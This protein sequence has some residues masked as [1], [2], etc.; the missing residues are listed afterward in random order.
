MWADVVAGQVR[1]KLTDYVGWVGMARLTALKI[2]GLV[3]PGRYGDGDGLWLQVRDAE[4]RSWLFRFTMDGR[5]R[6]MGL[7]PFPDVSLADAREAARK[8]RGMVREGLDPIANRRQQRAE[9]LAA[10]QAQTFA[11]V[12]ERYLGAHEAV[13]RNDKHRYQ[14]RQT[15]SVAS[16]AFG[17]HQVATISTGDVMRVLEPIWQTKSETASR[18]RGRIEAVLDYAT[19]HGWRTGENP[20]RWRGHLAK[21][22][23]APSKVA[24]V[25]HQP[26]LPWRQ[27][28][29]FM[30]G[31]RGQDGVAAFAL[32][33]TI[34]TA[35]RTG[36][37]IGARWSEIDL[38]SAVWSIPAARMKMNRPHRVPLNSAAMEVLEA[39]RPLRNSEDSDGWVFPGGR[40]DAALSNM[41]MLM[42]LRRM[43]PHDAGAP[44][45]WRDEVSGDP[46]SVHGF[47]STFRDWVSE[48]TNHSREV[49]EQ[50][51]AHVLPDAVEAAYRRGDLM[52]KRRR[53]MNDWGEFCSHPS[54]H[55]EVVQL[56][57]AV[58][59]G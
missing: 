15:L 40:R 48:C 52:E 2:K 14:W 5:Q 36:E 27:V 37:T 53:L 33:F 42:L 30:T 56:R 44:A 57:P 13:W 58:A 26:A 10:I 32:Q 18:L 23:P 39:V 43:N 49:A 59:A 20:A 25:K 45:K 51:L 16:A 41:S 17:S 12:V 19:A 50:A 46:I 47:R 4:H 54:R 31:L 6:Q 29:D 34:L 3:S 35:A 24:K 28:G 22:L 1:R 8:C 38:A 55:G 21:L 7:G 9:R 11:Q